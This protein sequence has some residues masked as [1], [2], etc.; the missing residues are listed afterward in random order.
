MSM[1]LPYFIEFQTYNRYLS[2]MIKLLQRSFAKISSVI[3]ETK[4]SHLRSPQWN[5][6][7]DAHLVEH[8]T[9]AACDGNENLQ[10]HHVLPFHLHPEKELDPDNLVTLCMGEWDCHLNIGHG[11]SFRAFNPHVHEDAYRFRHSGPMRHEIIAEAKK[12]REE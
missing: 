5:S 2:S 9:C 10:V 8:G 12:G 3:R 11:G 1:K 7:R 4:K 6:V